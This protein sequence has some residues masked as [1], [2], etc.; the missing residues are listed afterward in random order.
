MDYIIDTSAV[1]LDETPVEGIT[2]TEIQDLSKKQRW[3]RLFLFA[4]DGNIDGDDPD[5]YC[6]N[7]KFLEATCDGKVVGFIRLQ[8]N[9]M[10]FAMEYR[11]KIWCLWDAYVL[12]EYRHHG[13]F[14]NMIK[15][16]IANFDVKMVLNEE[17]IFKKYVKFFAPLGFSFHHAIQDD[18]DWNQCWSFQDSF[19]D[20]VTEM[21]G[22][23]GLRFNCT[24]VNDDGNPVD[25]QKAAWEEARQASSA[26]HQNPE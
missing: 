3:F 25:D 23:P 7:W 9:S 21:M 19:R 15:F 20:V 13:I 24:I 10:P 14:K 1:E 2:L 17:S 6:G 26:N 12:P 18:V 11:D 4:M 5:Q 22:V 16:A 8:D